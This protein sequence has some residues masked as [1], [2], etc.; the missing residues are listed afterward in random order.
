MANR[1][2]GS[3]LSGMSVALG[4][5]LILSFTSS[6]A[7]A[8]VGRTQGSFN[9]SPS[10]AA[11]YT[12]PIFTPPGPRG[13]QPSVALS[14]SSSAGNGYVGHGWSLSGFSAISRCRRTVAQDG[15]APPVTYGNADDPYCID[16]NRLRLLSGTYGIGGSVYGTEIADF[17]RIVAHTNG[18]AGPVYWTVERKD[19]LTYTYGGTSDSRVAVGGYGGTGTWM[20]SQISDRFGNK[21]KYTWETP[22]SSTI[23]MTHPVKIE[24]TQTSSGSGTYLYSMEFS[25]GANSSGSTFSEYVAAGQRLE[26][27]LLASITVKNS[28]SAVRKYVLTYDTS[29]TTNAKRLTQIKECADSAETDCISPTTVTYGNGA[30][31]FNISTPA[32][33]MANVGAEGRYDFNGDGYKD[34]AYASYGY[35]LY[36]RLG[37]SSGYGSPINTGLHSP[38][39]GKLLNIGSDQILGTDGTDWYIYAWNGSSFNALNTGFSRADTS[40]ADVFLTDMDGNQLDD[41]LFAAGTGTFPINLGGPMQYVEGPTIT[42]QYHLNA[43]SGTSPAFSSAGFETFEMPELLAGEFYDFYDPDY[44]T[45]ITYLYSFALR[46]GGDSDGDGRKELIMESEL[47]YFGARGES[48]YGSGLSY[49]GGGRRILHFTGDGYGW[50]ESAGLYPIIDD[51]NGDKC[52]DLGYAIYYYN[53]YSV[54]LSG[55]AGSDPPPF[56]GSGMY[57]GAADYN[58]DGR[59]DIF[60]MDR[61]TGNISVKPLMG[62]NTL[63]ASINTGIPAGRIRNSVGEAD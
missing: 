27:D 15:I 44:F 12:I 50:T 56:E 63:G 42:F 52:D 45:F 10:G 37:S 24:W 35:P 59:K 2:L 51:L 30:A 49:T 62:D 31:G 53:Q 47:G 21:V 41:I 34:L 16:G 40:Y 4:V 13:V 9:V 54:T 26:A 17:S 33:T 25:Y 19:G 61:D 6:L 38:Q 5:M 60:L 8:S 18:T 46:M 55:C 20:V 39:F 11:T 1:S 22:D 32:V 48:Y 36:I 14:Y 29:P 57:L 28:T 3:V 23:S 43:S 58:G 7:H